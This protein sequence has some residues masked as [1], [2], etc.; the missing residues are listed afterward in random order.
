[1]KTG[2]YNIKRK[3]R[4]EIGGMD[5]RFKGFQILLCP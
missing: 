1:M 5:S 4:C 2:N 3:I